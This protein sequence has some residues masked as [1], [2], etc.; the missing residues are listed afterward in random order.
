MLRRI[1]KILLFLLVL[2]YVLT[3][4][5]VFIHPPSTLML[6]GILTFHKVER[7]WVGLERISPA[8]IKAVVAAEDSAFC[9]HHGFDLKQMEK[10]LRQAEARNRPLKGA[11]TISQQLAKNLFL[12]HGRSWIRKFLEA[13]LT[14]WIELL[15]PKSTIMETYLNT[16]EWGD[17]IYGAE[18][19]AQHYF[20]VSARALSYAQAVQLATSLPN[21]IERNA[22]HPGPAQRQ[23]AR[24]L[25]G[26][27]KFNAPDV[28]CLR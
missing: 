10:S 26:R 16:A 3:P 28:S 2:P 11:S 12:W 8:L 21:P 4:I 13:P 14:L 24:Q 20:G 23:M 25:M 9:T 17:G 1:F 27:L 19:A 15:W 6:E 18:A 22:G 7:D 5:Y